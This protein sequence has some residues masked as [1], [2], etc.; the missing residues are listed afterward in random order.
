[1]DSIEVRERGPM[2][3][4]NPAILVGV[5]RGAENLKEN[6]TFVV[7]SSKISKC[8]VMLVVHI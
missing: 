6:I 1:M 4:Y 7:E 8:S 3:E 5:T 2:D